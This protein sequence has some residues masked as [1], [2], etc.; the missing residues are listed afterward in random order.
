MQVITS[1]LDTPYHLLPGP[2]RPPP[3]TPT[4]PTTAVTSADTCTDA[5]D[6]PRVMR[7]W[8]DWRSCAFEARVDPRLCAVHAWIKLNCRK[9]CGLCNVSVIGALKMSHHAGV[10][11]VR[12]ARAARYSPVDDGMS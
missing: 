9:A 3:R 4:D 11:K 8:D 1:A 12:D 5:A 2:S 6:L 10:G 7:P